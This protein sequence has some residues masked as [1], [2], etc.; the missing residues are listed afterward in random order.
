MV[1][2]ITQ[3]IT[4]VEEI[5]KINEIIDDAEASKVSIENSLNTLAANSANIDLSNLSTVG[6]EIL[7]N[8]LNKQMISNCIAH[9]PQGIKLELNNGTLTLKSGSKVYV[10]NG[11]G[12]FNEITINSDE[13]LTNSFSG[14]YDSIFICWDS[15]NNVMRQ[16]PTV[17]SGTSDPSTATNRFWYDISANKIKY[18]ENSGT[19][20]TSD[21]LSLPICIMQNEGSGGGFTKIQQVFNGFGYIGSTVFVLPGVK[22]LSPIGRNTGGSLKSITIE[23]T[24]IVTR[25]FSTTILG[26]CMASPNRVSYPISTRTSDVY[27]E[28]NNLFTTPELNGVAF[29]IAGIVCDSAGKITS[30]QPKTVF[31]AL[32]FNDKSTIVGWGMPDYDSGITI[33]TN[34]NTVFAKNGYVSYIPGTSTTNAGKW[35]ACIIKING[36]TV[37]SQ[38]YYSTKNGVNADAFMCAVGAGDT[39]LVSSKSIGSV[40]FYPCKGE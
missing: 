2:K 38:S 40:V 36:H 29:D 9:I 15:A 27:I 23:N 13:T 12:I 7:D 28:E 19:T 6:Q 17:N 14:Q 20:V 39:I 24:Q 5:E 3:P 21:K 33:S 35:N 30:F 4:P 32:D 31:H 11:S 25:T 34:V 16:T 26:F 18:Y 1:D 10:P 8:K 22:G 37:C